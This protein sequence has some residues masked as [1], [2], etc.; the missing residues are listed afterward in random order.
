MSEKETNTHIPRSKRETDPRSIIDKKESRELLALWARWYRQVEGFHE[1]SAE[2]K[3]YRFKNT[4]WTYFNNAKELDPKS[5]GQLEIIKKTIPFVE[6]VYDVIKTHYCKDFSDLVSYRI[7]NRGTLELVYKNGK[8]D[9]ITLLG[10]SIELSREATAR[11]VIKEQSRISREVIRDRYDIEEYLGGDILV[12]YEKIKGDIPTWAVS[13]LWVGVGIEAWRNRGNNTLYRIASVMYR[14]AKWS[15]ERVKVDKAQPLVATKEEFKKNVASYLSEHGVSYDAIT[16]SF[17]PR[18]IASLHRVQFDI[19][20]MSFDDF[21]REVWDANAKGVGRHRF[22]AWRQSI[23]RDMTSYTNSSI[24]K[25]SEEILQGFQKWY[26]EAKLR[27]LEWLNSPVKWVKIGATWAVKW[28][29]EYL[30]WWVFFKKYHAN[31][32]DSGTLY[33]SLGEQA[34][35]RVGAALGASSKILPGKLGTLVTGI[36]IGA[37][38]VIEW[39][40]AANAIWLDKKFWEYYP[41]REDEEYKDSW[42]DGKSIVD[43]IIS[44]EAVHGI[45]DKAKVDIRLPGTR[46]WLEVWTG[47]NTSIS[48]P[49]I[50][51]YQHHIDFGTDPRLYLSSS[52]WRDA[53][54]WEE[55][56]TEYQKW[57]MPQ[58]MKILDAYRSKSGYFQDENVRERIPDVT[59]IKQEYSK[60]N[61]R[62]I[63][64]HDTKTGKIISASMVIMPQGEIVELPDT[65]GRKTINFIATLTN[66]DGFVEDLSKRET[67]QNDIAIKREQLLRSRLRELFGTSISG[68]ILKL[69]SG[70][71]SSGWQQRGNEL[72]EYISTIADISSP[73]ELEKRVWF[74]LINQTEMLR[75]TPKRIEDRKHALI[76][77]NMIIEQDLIRLCENISDPRI[78]KYL[79]S[80]FDRIKK[81]ERLVQISEYDTKILDA[82]KTWKILEEKSSWAWIKTPAFLGH[83]GKEWIEWMEHLWFRTLIGD[84][85]EIKNA[86]LKWWWQIWNS[87]S[88]VTFSDT[89]YALLNRMVNHKRDME[90]LDNISK[91]GYATKWYA[92]ETVDR[93]IWW[94]K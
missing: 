31:M 89:F 11:S 33:A 88:G 21:A 10:D 66:R 24:G 22:E 73:V 49:D 8:R 83:E 92:P 17:S 62:I 42:R 47:K 70:E 63:I 18:G 4:L 27:F 64:T 25:S 32:Q 82:K 7:D 61:E 59:Q 93:V 67:P 26:V 28:P 60:W 86:D 77:E 34:L 54:S 20:R 3:E 76:W 5:P 19:M 53:T 36:G 90:F 35:F 9:F 1:L 14:T 39:E 45:L 38:F 16:K 87:G 58:V 71:Q 23:I 12:T 91:T 94:K 13:L 43:H 68:A 51:L 78:K 56:I 81:K 15:Y 52:P 74:W 46:G 44:G 72:A 50:R 65:T 30:M 57:L 2:E 37:F 85:S 69:I 84:N 55:R 41:D 48:L 6:G 80:L 29:F 40:H 79:L 75:I